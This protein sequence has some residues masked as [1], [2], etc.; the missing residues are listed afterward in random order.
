V[1]TTEPD[2]DDVPNR[3]SVRTDP[4]AGYASRYKTLLEAQDALGATSKT[5]AILGACRHTE[6]DCRGK[7]RALEYLSE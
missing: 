6:R 2:F 3:V 1:D 7:R 4:D 5:K